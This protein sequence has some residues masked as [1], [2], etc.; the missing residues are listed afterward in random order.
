MRNKKNWKVKVFKAISHPVRV[1]IIEL[2]ARKT[3]CVGE[4]VKDLDDSFSNVSRHLNVLKNAEIVVG[5]KR[6]LEIYYSVE[7][8]CVVEFLRCLDSLYDDGV[9]KICGLIKKYG[10]DK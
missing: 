4:L 2:L 5:E 3:M 6:G 10:G 1:K 7:L 8:W 9:C